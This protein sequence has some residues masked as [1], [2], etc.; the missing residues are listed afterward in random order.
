MFGKHVESVLA[1]RAKV[2]G[3]MADLQKNFT[4]CPT[5]K[6]FLGLNQWSYHA[7]VFFFKPSCALSQPLKLNLKCSL[8]GRPP[9]ELRPPNLGH[10]VQHAGRSCCEG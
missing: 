2:R 4:D 8:Q 7:T 6:K 1:K 5:A 10:A 9:A 3:L